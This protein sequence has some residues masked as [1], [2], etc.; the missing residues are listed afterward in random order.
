MENQKL[1]KNI[2]S[3]LLSKSAEIE[4][5]IGAQSNTDL[6]GASIEAEPE[7][8]SISDKDLF[9]LPKAQDDKDREDSVLPPEVDNSDSGGDSE[10]ADTEKLDQGYSA[11]SDKT[12][13]TYTGSG[14]G[15]KI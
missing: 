12:D 11:S 6:F 10:K 5:E 14:D 13:D 3:S 1:A 8:P 4:K 2:V 7:S 9:G 15:P